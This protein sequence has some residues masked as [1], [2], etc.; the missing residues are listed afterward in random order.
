[1]TKYQ[2]LSSGRIVEVFHFWVENM[3]E[4]FTALQPT[5][6]KHPYKQ[7]PLHKGRCLIEQNGEKLIVYGGDYIVLLNG[8]VYSVPFEEFESRFVSVSEKQLLLRGALRH[9]ES[10]SNQEIIDKLNTILAPYHIQLDV[11]I[12]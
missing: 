5:L 10:L 12:R 1:M 8:I 3:P 9:Y 7:Q 11:S 6:S 4:W 2:E